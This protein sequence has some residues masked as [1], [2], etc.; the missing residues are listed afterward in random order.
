[1]KKTIIISVLVILV[2]GV[3]LFRCSRSGTQEIKVTKVS[4]G[5]IVVTVSATGTVHSNTEAKLTTISGGR[6]NSIMVEENQA[7]EK[8]DMLLKLDCTEQTE[9]DY[10]RLLNLGEKGFVSSQQVEVA[11][12]QWKNTFIAAPFRG[13]VAKKFVE[14]GETLIGGSPAF[15]IADLKNMIVETNIDETDIGTVKVGQQVEVVLDAYKDRKLRGGVHFIARTS[16]EAKEKGITYPVKIKLQPTDVIL[17]IGMT[18]DVSIKVAERENALVVPYTAI[19]EEKERRFVFLVEKGM[20]KKKIVET[21]LE[22]YDS[23]EIISG[24]KDGDVIVESN[25]AK[26]KENQRVKPKK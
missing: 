8:G 6:I 26:L 18:G 14:V 24:V 4:R 17:R 11:R 15:L 22:S 1:M 12:E 16:L 5:K 2:L 25:V 10:K 7:V 19:G 13:T 20:L 23:T 21:G 9:K 3:I